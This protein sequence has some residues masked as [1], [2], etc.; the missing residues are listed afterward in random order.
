[1][2]HVNSETASETSLPSVR[3]APAL[4][5]VASYSSTTSSSRQALLFRIIQDWPEKVGLIIIA[6]AVSTV[7]FYMYQKLWN[8]V[9]SGQK[10]LQ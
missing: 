3:S 10:L 7:Y 5:Q 9:A 6:V 1:M 4:Q 2:S 8:L